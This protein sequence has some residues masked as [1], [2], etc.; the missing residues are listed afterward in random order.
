MF[1]SFHSPYDLRAV[2]AA[3]PRALVLG[4]SFVQRVVG[5]QFSIFVLVLNCLLA[6]VFVCL[7]NC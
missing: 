4:H 3:K 1:T 2:M 7:G 6:C 5:Q